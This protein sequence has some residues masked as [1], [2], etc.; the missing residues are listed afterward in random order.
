M[1]L[2]LLT[3]RILLML[4]P[5]T[6][7]PE[8]EEG[9]GGT[10]EPLPLPM[11]ALVLTGGGTGSLDG[12]LL[13]SV[14]AIYRIQQNIFIIRNLYITLIMGYYYQE[15]IILG[16]VKRHFN[17]VHV[18]VHVAPIHMQRVHALPIQLIFSLRV[19]PLILLSLSLSLSLFLWMIYSSDHWLSY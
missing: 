14:L 6:V 7:A 11:E 1:K 17:K 18:H 19:Q 12:I 3:P 15:Y 16:I 10:F 8:R 9:R 13:L 4:R 2:S 5:R